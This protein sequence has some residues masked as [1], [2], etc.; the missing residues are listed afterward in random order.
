MAYFSDPAINESFREK[1]LSEPAFVAAGPRPRMYFDPAWTRVAIVTCGGL[2]PGLND[3]I[4]ALVNTLYTA[5]GVDNVFGIRYGYRGLVPSYGLK[6]I[7]HILRK[8]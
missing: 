5:Y 8:R 6:F 3:V 7:R 1:G 2:C 4:R